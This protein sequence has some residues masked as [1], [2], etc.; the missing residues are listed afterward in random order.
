MA[1]IIDR[2]KKV[3]YLLKRDGP[4]C[5]YCGT[6]LATEATA[7]GGRLENQVT[8]DHIIPRS[9]GG[10]N[11]LENFVL[12]CPGCNQWKGKE[13]YEKHCARCR[14]RYAR[15]AELAAERAVLRP[16]PTVSRARSPGNPSA[17]RVHSGRAGERPAREFPPRRR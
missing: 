14:A 9:R 3:R 11:H 13:F 2:A 1:K 7:K 17:S 15:A 10:G 5:H 4:V 16:C 12:S 6:R 8:L